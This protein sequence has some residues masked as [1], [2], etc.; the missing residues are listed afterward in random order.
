MVSSAPLSTVIILPLLVPRRGFPFR[1]S[2]KTLFVS[3]VK[4]P[5]T[6]ARRVNV[7]PFVSFAAA[8][9]SLNFAK[10]ASPTCATSTTG[11]WAHFVTLFSVMQEL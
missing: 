11:H 6:S 5:F 8:T 7:L 10:Y 2:V 1:S 3:T 9:A 4:S